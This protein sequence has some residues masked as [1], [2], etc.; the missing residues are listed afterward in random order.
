MN[1]YDN[2]QSGSIEAMFDSIAPRYDLLNHLLSAG[3][4]RR[5]RSA[6][7]RT[8]RDGAPARVLDVATG[9]ADMAIALARK[10]PGAAVVG[11]D[12][13]EGMLARGRQK[14]SHAS[15]CGRITLQK[16]DA[17]G[18][19][20]ADGE[21]DAATVAF[22]VRNFADMEGGLREIRRVLRPGGRLAILEFSTPRNSF[23]RRLYRLYFLRALPGIGGA[24]SGDRRAYDYLPSSVERFPHPE[25]FLE[26]LAAAG[27]ADCRARALTGGIVYLYTG[28]SK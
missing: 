19:E 14:A 23:F 9:T 26:I 13:S 5:W 24:V 12:L 15:L 3:I 7:V 6:A 8:L 18:L 20:F 17:A 21:F 4:D 27:F 10:L 22:G 25:R 28:I 16:G 2:K 1:P 11:V